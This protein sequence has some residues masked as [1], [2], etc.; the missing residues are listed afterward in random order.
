MKKKSSYYTQGFTLVEL[1]VVMTMFAIITTLSFINI[2]GLISH[3]SLDETVEQVISDVK[4]QQL[5]ALSGE[6]VQGSARYGVHF[7]TNSYTLFS[8][9][10]YVPGDSH[11]SV[12]TMPANVSFTSTLP[13]NTIFFSE[14]SGEVV[15]YDSN[16][17]RVTI[18]SSASNQSQQLEFNVLGVIQR[19]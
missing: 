15:S 11:N 1:M 2:S 9:N 8:G 7:D 18:N 10:S 3:T 13:S 17:D 14:K 19:L 6:Q 12:V 16:A 5:R 4:R